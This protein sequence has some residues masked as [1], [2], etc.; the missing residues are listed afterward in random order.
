MIFDLRFR[1]DDHHQRVVV[2][3]PARGAITFYPNKA[4]LNHKPLGP[5]R[6]NRFRS[7]NH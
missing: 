5:T 6:T 2:N 4:L 7:W 1:T 3:K